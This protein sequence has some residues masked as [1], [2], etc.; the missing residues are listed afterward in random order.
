MSHS[1]G[2]YQTLSLG[3][4]AQAIQASKEYCLVRQGR[5]AFV[6]GAHNL[7]KGRLVKGAQ[8]AYK[9]KNGAVLPSTSLFSRGQ[10]KDIAFRFSR[11][12][13]L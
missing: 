13:L 7:R 4:F 12:G 3:I 6:Y 10:R 9:I 2:K 5:D 1:G 8:P 11:L